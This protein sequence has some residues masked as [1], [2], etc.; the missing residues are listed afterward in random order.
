MTCE[1]KI[2][3]DQFFYSVV[4]HQ[5]PPPPHGRHAMKFLLSIAFGLA[6]SGQALAQCTKDTDCKGDRI[7]EKGVCTSPPTQ[8]SSVPAATQV[9][10]APAPK[11]E[12]YPAQRHSGPWTVPKGFR[13]IS[14]NEWRNEFGKLVA[15]PTMNFAGRYHLSINSCGTGCRYYMLTDLPTGKDLS[16]LAPFASAEPPPKTRD[17]HNYSTDLIARPDSAMLIAQYNVELPSGVECRERVF[18]LE[19][20]RLRAITN[21]KVGCSKQ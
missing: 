10:D 12:D 16:I 5:N 9:Q 21:T 19:G 20:E 18:V 11:F 3:Q 2:W 15:P 13:R 17:G 8:R 1:H 7:C 14:A 4:R 6:V